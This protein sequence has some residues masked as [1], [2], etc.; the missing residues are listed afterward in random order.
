MADKRERGGMPINKT[1]HKYWLELVQNDIDKYEK[2]LG[3]DTV[4]NIL[5]GNAAECY[6]CG[7]EARLQRCHIVPHCCGGS[8]LADNLFLMCLRCHQDNPDTVYADMFFHYVR[9]RES[10]VNFSWGEVVRVMKELVAEAKAED[11]EKVE[12]FQKVP[13]REQM[14]HHNQIDN[15]KMGVS[16][17]NR[18][19][20]NTFVH[21]AWKNITEHWNPEPSLPSESA[22]C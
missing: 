13:I 2:V 10:Y 17:N 11:L 8:D 18:L 15:D 12:L 21:A 20:V 4:V 5:Y 9:H 3:G 6:A 16:L 7:C 22:V 19:N 14:S 1:I